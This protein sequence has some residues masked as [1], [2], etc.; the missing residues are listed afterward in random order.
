L[1]N[2]TFWILLTGGR[3]TDLCFPSSQYYSASANA[4]MM[5]N[6]NQ[7]ISTEDSADLLDFN[8]TSILAGQSSKKPKFNEAIP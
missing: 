4:D 8:H 7:L 5:R 3:W 2:F 1:E 6:E